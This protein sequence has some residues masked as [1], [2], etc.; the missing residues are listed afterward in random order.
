MRPTF[1][2]RSLR[3]VN[4]LHGVSRSIVRRLAVCVLASA[5]LGRAMAQE[6]VAPGNPADVAA[7]RAAATAYAEALAR[8]DAD[9]VRAIWTDDGD[10]VDG[11]GQRSRGQG[12]DVVVPGEG[13]AAPPGGRRPETRLRFLSPDVAI[14]DGSVDMVL[15]GTQA[16]L[17]G[18]F[19]ALWVRGEDGW[20]LAGLR[21][22]ER[23]AAADADMLEELDWLV[24]EWVLDV[25]EQALGEGDGRHDL[26][27]AT[28]V[29]VRWDEGRAFL[30]RDLRVPVAAEDA[31]AGFVE[32][33]QRIGWDPIV[34]RVRS[35]GF[36]SDGSRSEATLFRDGASWVAV[37]TVF[38]PD[39]RQESTTIVFSP[40]GPDRCVWR[41]MPESFDADAGRPTR[42]VWVR[43]T[44]EEKR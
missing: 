40:D 2:S 13:P 39:G 30:V 11:W 16:A 41:I 12:I 26:P 35:W 3:K 27:A 10:I 25:D 5:C 22:S 21:E 6:T 34:Q 7:I 33:H 17:E 20:K 23:P 4:R 29:S 42:A 15:P 9:A 24:G 19:S 32:V 18:W 1:L 44:M 37:Q 43:Q 38:L 8:G 31:P 28:R 36:S 14:E